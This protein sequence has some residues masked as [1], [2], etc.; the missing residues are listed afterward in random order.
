[1]AIIVAA[2]VLHYIT[3]MKGGCTDQAFYQITV[4]ASYRLYTFFG[5][6]F[7]LDILIFE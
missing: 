3:D 2:I 6:I 7:F 1:M 4:Y 5:E